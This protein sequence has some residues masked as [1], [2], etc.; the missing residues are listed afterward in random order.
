MRAALL[1]SICQCTFQAGS[2]FTDSQPNCRVSALMIDAADSVSLSIFRMV[3]FVTERY[4][5][6]QVIN[7]RSPY[8]SPSS[9]NAQCD[10]TQNSSHPGDIRAAEWA[11]AIACAMAGAVLGFP[12]AVWICSVR[13]PLCDASDVYF[14]KQSWN[15]AC[16]E[17]PN[18]VVP[19]WN[20]AH[21]DK[22]MIWG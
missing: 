20:M 21:Y 15:L 6:C 16:P 18:T 5:P 22:Q 8:V 7:G 1:M 9:T 4:T 19:A 11:E 17:I 10:I 2:S 14:S 12:D 3:I 13:S